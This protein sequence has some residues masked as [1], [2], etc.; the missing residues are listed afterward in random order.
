LPRP[1]SCQVTCDVLVKLRQG[2]HSKDAFTKNLHEL[3]YHIRRT[4]GTELH[5]TELIAIGVIDPS[6]PGIGSSRPNDGQGVHSPNCLRL[7]AVLAPL[8]VYPVA[9]VVKL[10]DTLS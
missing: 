8:Y 10:V 5:V 6:G 7:T 4:D 1:F 2:T 3:A 9:L